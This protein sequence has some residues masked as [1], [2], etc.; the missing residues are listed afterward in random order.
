MSIALKKRQLNRLTNSLCLL[1]AIGNSSFWSESLIIVTDSLLEQ[2]AVFSL[3]RRIVFH[4][5]QK[6]CTH[7]CCFIRYS[8]KHRKDQRIVMIKVSTDVV[9]FFFSSNSHPQNLSFVRCCLLAPAVSMLSICSQKM[10]P[11]HFPW[12]NY[13]TRYPGRGRLRVDARR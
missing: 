11:T 7:C 12:R 3:A 2:V 13:T 4:K 10:S 1:S 5:S 6:P 9:C 8:S